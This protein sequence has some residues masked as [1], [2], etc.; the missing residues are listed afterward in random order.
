MLYLV[1]AINDIKLRD[2]DFNY[3]LDMLPSVFKNKILKR[4]RWK[5]A[6]ALLLGKL[7][8]KH[9]L[10]THE[11]QYT[12]NDVRLGDTG[13]PYINDSFDFNITHSGSYVVC[14]YSN[15]G[16]IGVDLEIIETIDVSNFKNIFE[17]TELEQIESSEDRQAS[18]YD[19][20]TIKEAAI[21]A[22]GRGLIMPLKKIK[23]KDNKVF[24]EG[25]EWFYKKIQFQKN[26]TLH[27]A[28]S[29]FI[30]E[31]SELLKIKF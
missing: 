5:D 22:D 26:Y 10:L 30:E 16:K 29:T 6:Q 27:I 2:E 24:I 28:T 31:I 9:I 23:V 3:Y 13:R 14:A 15:E 17:E 12:L 1:Y 19:L 8:L 4:R 7:L 11:S 20:W 25:C 21:K 18:F